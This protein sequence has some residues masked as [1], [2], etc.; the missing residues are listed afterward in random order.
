[1]SFSKR[2]IQINELDRI[3]RLN[4][5][6]HETLK[7][8]GELQRI[9]NYNKLSKEDLIYAL[10]KSKIPNDNNYITH[11]IN[12][13]ETSEL[14]NEIR[15]IIKNIRETVTRLGSILTNKGRTRKNY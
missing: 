13:I 8:P 1:M 12:N 15:A 11:I 14:D 10:L 5:L 7:K 9:K 3:Q 2:H 4:E 6:S